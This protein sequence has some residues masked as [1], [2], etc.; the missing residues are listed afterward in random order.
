VVGVYPLSPAAAA[1]IK[2]GDIITTVDGST[3]TGGDELTQILVKRRPGEEVTLGV[4]RDDHETK[5]KV[6]LGQLNKLFRVR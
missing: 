5:I 1:G 3:I 4:L 6:T 2:I